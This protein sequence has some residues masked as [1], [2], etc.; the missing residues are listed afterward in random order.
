[1]A[2]PVGM[3]DDMS[4]EQHGNPRSGWL[5]PAEGSHHAAAV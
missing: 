2:E 3:E 1:V 5:S 4:D